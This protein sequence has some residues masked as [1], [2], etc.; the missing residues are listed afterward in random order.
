MKVE[1]KPAYASYPTV[2]YGWLYIAIGMRYLTFTKIWL[3]TK[4]SPDS[5][6]PRVGHTTLSPCSQLTT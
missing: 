1:I 4:E 3:T 6:L 2:R 5:E